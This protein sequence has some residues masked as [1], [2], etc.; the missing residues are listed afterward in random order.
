MGLD[1]LTLKLASESPYKV[2][3]RRSMLTRGLQADCRSLAII[4]SDSAFRITMRPSSFLSWLNMESIRAI[5]QK[6]STVLLV[7]FSSMARTRT[8]QASG[9]KP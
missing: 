9:W 4:P 6:F 7:S 8:A 1:G 5:A 3:I 2:R